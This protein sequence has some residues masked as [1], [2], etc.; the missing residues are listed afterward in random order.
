[1]TSG[2]TGA[3]EVLIGTPVS[4]AGELI[5]YVLTAVLILV[6]LDAMLRIIYLIIERMF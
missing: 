1:M 2:F 6:V 3:V 4:F 5:L